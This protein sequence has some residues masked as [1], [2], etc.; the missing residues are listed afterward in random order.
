M[1]AY[2]FMKKLMDNENNVVYQFGPNENSKGKIQFNKLTKKFTIIEEVEP[3]TVSSASYE[4]WAAEKIMRIVILG[5]GD[6]PDITS[7]E[8]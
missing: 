2:V 3:G 4:R 5:K 8:K 6:F 7:V 1:A